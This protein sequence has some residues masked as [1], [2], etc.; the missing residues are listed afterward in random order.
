MRQPTK[1]G[2]V[3]S[4][5]AFVTPSVARPEP[6]RL[7]ECAVEPLTRDQRHAV[8]PHWGVVNEAVRGA[9]AGVSLASLS[10]Q[11]RVEARDEVLARYC[12]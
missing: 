4:P 12:W 10:V 11:P 6:Q 2:G 3:S 1:S 8:R 7:L 5:F 9:L